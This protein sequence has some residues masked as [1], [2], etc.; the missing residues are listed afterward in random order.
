LKGKIMALAPTFALPSLASIAGS[1]GNVSSIVSGITGL[2]GKKK[3]APSTEDIARSQAHIQGELQKDQ[4]EVNMAMAKKHKIH[5]L[6]ALG[7]QPNAAPVQQ[8]DIG[9]IRG[10]NLERAARAGTPGRADKEMQA[11][12]L[13]RAQLENDLLRSQI[14]NV[15]KQAGDPPVGAYTTHQ[16][17]NVSR[18]PNDPGLSAGSLNPPPAGKKFTVGQT[19]HGKVYITL[20]ASGQADEYGEVYGAIK[21]LEYLAK[22]GYV[23]YSNGT[24]KAGKKLASYLRGQKKRK[25]PYSVNTNKGYSKIHW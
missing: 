5:P 14:S 8:Y 4:W 13:E 12:A 10:Q 1:V 18:S 24:Y 7:I 25:R 22:R 9:D 23:H 21:G 6:V 2:F 20:P 11:L 16:D 19:P 15:N 3:K 17:E